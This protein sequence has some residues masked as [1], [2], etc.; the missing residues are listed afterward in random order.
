MD[1]ALNGAF[2][3]ALLLSGCAVGPNY[4]SLPP[5]AADAYAAEIPVVQDEAAGAA[6]GETQRFQPGQDLPGQWWRLFGSAVLDALIEQAMSNYPDIAAQQAA[7]RAARENVR[8][9]G[10]ALLPQ[11]QGSASAARELVSGASIAPGAPGFITNI[12]QGNVS[13]SYAFDLFGG[14]RRA[15]R[16]AGSQ[17]A[18]GH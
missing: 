8:A 4:K 15:N 1:S 17:A 16:R 2:V 12:F 14:E 3:L 5:P 6:R 13:V 7:L 10:A 9:A 11:G 18:R